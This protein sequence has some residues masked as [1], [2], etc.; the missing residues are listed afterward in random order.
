MNPADAAIQ[1]L[2]HP[3]VYAIANAHGAQAHC[4][5]C[6]SVLAPGWTSWPSGVPESTVEPLGAL[7]LAGDD[8]PTYDEMRPMGMDSWSPDMPISLKHYPANRCEVWA[9]VSCHKP[10]LRYTEYGG[11]YVDKR[12]RELDPRRLVTEPTPSS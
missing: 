4:T 8:E 6:A 11:Y 9:C 7:W 10:F 3:E 5:T 1:R 2:S 12:V